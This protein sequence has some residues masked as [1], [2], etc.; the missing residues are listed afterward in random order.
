M[1]DSRDAYYVFDSPI[2]Y[3]GL[4]IYPIRMRDYLLFYRL[5]TCLMLEK[6]SIPDIK[7]IQMSYLQYMFHISDK[8][9]N[10]I[11]LFDGLL[12]LVLNKTNEDYK[13]SYSIGNDARPLFQIGKITYNSDDFDIIRKIITEQ[14]DLLLPDETIQKEVRD[15][16][17]EARRFKQK[18]NK[19]KI[20]SFEEQIMALALYSGWELEKIYDMTI[21]K[22]F[23]SI[24]RANHMIMSNIYLT[25]SM[26]GFVTF[27]DKSVLRGWLADLENED[28]KHAEMIDL[29]AVKNKINSSDAMN[30]T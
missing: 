24:K 21:R 25:A 5:A 28:K 2:P 13:I 27:K 4:L 11:A 17:E 8:E 7:I 23:M 16:I 19:T 6:N 15:K 18:I 9:N 22:F 12:R 3:K 20:A 14:N 26:S 30:K 29:D 10:Y 1:S